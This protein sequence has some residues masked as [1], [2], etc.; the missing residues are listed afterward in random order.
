MTQRSCQEV[1]HFL[2]WYE[3]HREA[4]PLPR[5]WTEDLSEIKAYAE[6]DTTNGYPEMVFTKETRKGTVKVEVD[7]GLPQT[8]EVFITAH[9][10]EEIAA[11]ELDELLRVFLNVIRQEDDPGELPVEKQEP[12][13][14]PWFFNFYLSPFPAP[15]GVCKRYWGK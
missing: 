13:N 5:D 10:G 14:P 4:N 7:V 2:R 15:G 12:E 3:E 1:R 9:T 6:D 11:E 8:G